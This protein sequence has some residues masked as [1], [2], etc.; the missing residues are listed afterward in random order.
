MLK[1]SSK[2][3]FAIGIVGAVV[4]GS[5]QVGA[6]PVTSHQSGLTSTPVIQVARKRNESEDQYRKR[7]WVAT[8]DKRGFGYFKC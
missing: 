4:L 3:G 8:D 5:A 7:C 6:F 2:I 1:E